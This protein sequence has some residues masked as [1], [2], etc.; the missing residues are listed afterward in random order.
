MKTQAEIRKQILDLVRLY[1]KSA[2][3]ETFKEVRYAGR[4]FDEKEI[5]NA[6]EASL[7]FFLT[8]GK[9][10]AE[11]NNL[12]RQFTGAKFSMLVNSG[13]SANLIALSTLT[14]ESLG[15]DRLK[16]GDEVITVACGFP[17]TVNPIIQNGLVPVFVDIDPHT[18]NVNVKELIQAV[19]GKTR[20]VML[21]H[22]L[23]NPFDIE[24]V[25]GLC[26]EAGL[27][28]I[29]DCCDALGSTYNGIHVGNFGDIATCSFYPA[30]HIT[31]GEG[32][33]VF[34]NSE[35]V[36]RISQSFRDWGRDC[37]CK[38]GDNDTCGCRF[39]RNYGDLPLGYDHKYVY[40]EIGYN[41]K[42]T[43]IQ[44]SIGVAQL[45]KLPSFI[46]YRKHNFKRWSTELLPLSNYFEFP[47]ATRNSDPSW[48]A[49]PITI[50]DNFGF[51]RT[52]LTTFLS[53][54]LIETRNVFAGN[55]TKQP[56]YKNIEKRIASDLKVTDNVM[57]NTFF[58]GCYPGMTGDHIRYTVDK[59]DEFVRSRK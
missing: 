16:R 2:P 22:T 37:Y 10:S 26:V 48:F 46:N 7:D 53:K 30:H 4:V 59:I 24:Y 36:A 43:D 18:Y 6:V 14:S 54:N 33:A 3:E 32:G 47:V 57:N 42:V 20:A 1:H 38:G 8:E 19:S 44:A 25:K 52:E 21:A 56:A 41:L 9:W 49:F 34:T 12:F 5:Q 51:S 13:S 23:G 45:R 40:S 17:T 28:L 35:L 58:L 11:F 31:M 55:L 50:K 27:Y 15:K 29:E 39:T